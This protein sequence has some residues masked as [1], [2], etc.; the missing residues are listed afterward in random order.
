MIQM[1]PEDLRDQAG[2]ERAFAYYFSRVQQEEP[3]TFNAMLDLKLEACRYDAQQ[4]V[5]RM[6]ARPWMTN[7]GGILHGGIIASALDFAM[8]LLCRYCSGGAMTPTVSMEVGYLRPAPVEGAILVG[9][10]IVKPGKTLMNA[11]AKMWLPG[12]EDRALA[13]ATG[14]YFVPTA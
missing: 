5:L 10:E 3:G 9:A 4:L 6:E 12:R 13:A 2:M 11:S 14:I 7:P 1:L 8:G